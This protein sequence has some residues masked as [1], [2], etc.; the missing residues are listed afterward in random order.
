MPQPTPWLASEP[1]PEFAA[2]ADAGLEI[3]ELKK[4]YV[5]AVFFKTR[6]V[7]QTAAI[8]KVDRSF[9]YNHLAR[10]AP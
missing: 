7:L 4:L 5:R 3:E 9:V 2:L 8:L 6:S 1:S 10:R